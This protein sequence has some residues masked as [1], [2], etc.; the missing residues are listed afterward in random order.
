MKDKNKQVLMRYNDIED[1]QSNI[2]NHN[3]LTPFVHKDVGGNVYWL[4]QCSDN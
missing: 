1:H 3:T 2:D 4:Q